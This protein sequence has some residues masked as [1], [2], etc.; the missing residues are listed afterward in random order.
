[1]PVRPLRMPLCMSTILGQS[2]GPY[3]DRAVRHSDW[4][5]GAPCLGQ[6]HSHKLAAD[7]HFV[8][9]LN[10]ATHFGAGVVAVSKL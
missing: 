5:H 1:M 8:S 7:A 9:S 3:L 10:L 6:D 2:A 4:K